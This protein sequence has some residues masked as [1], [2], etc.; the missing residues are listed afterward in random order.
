LRQ[1]TQPYTLLRETGGNVTVAY[2]E[3]LCTWLHT[4]LNFVIRYNY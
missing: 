2:A 4:V 3:H 1:E